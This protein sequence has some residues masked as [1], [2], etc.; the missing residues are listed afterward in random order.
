MVIVFLLITVSAV[1][2]AVVHTFDFPRVWNRSIWIVLYIFLYELIRRFA[3][4]MV[5]YVSGRAERENP[6]VY[7][8]EALLY[9]VTPVFMFAV[10]I[11]DIYVFVVFAVIMLVR[12]STSM[13]KF[14]P[15]PSKARFLMAVLL[16][17]LGFRHSK[18]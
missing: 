6:L 12:V 1:L 17:P 7:I 10:N 16:F 15:V 11:N 13:M 9:V 18:K 14:A 4:L 3:H 2:G 5:C 8:L